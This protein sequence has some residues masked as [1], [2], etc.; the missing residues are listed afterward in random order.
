MYETVGS[1]GQKNILTFT[2]KKKKIEEK[3]SSERIKKWNLYENTRDG[4]K[5]ADV[6]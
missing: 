5:T 1:N 3:I 4:M 2:K 6:D